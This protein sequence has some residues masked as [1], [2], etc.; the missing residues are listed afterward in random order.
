MWQQRPAPL[1]VL[2]AALGPLA[3]RSAQKFMELKK[4][5]KIDSRRFL[6]WFNRTDPRNLPSSLVKV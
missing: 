6:K 5:V 3:A 4:V 1:T 2:A